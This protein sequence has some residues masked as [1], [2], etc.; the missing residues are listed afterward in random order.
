MEKHAR[1]RMKTIPIGDQAH[2]VW[3]R[4]C[5]AKKMTST[6]LMDELIEHVAR[7]QQNRFYLSLPKVD[8]R[9]KILTGT[10]IDG[11]YKK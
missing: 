8:K 3:R 5:K 10:K 7:Q 4:W 6:E 1:D 11:F 9:G 2:T